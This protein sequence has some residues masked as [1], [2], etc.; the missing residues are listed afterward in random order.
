MCYRILNVFQMT[1]KRSNVPPKRGAR[2]N[3]RANLLRQDNSPS[4]AWPLLSNTIN[5]VLEVLGLILSQDHYR[6]LSH[7]KFNLFELLFSNF[8]FQNFILLG[9]KKVRAQPL[10]NNDIALSPAN[11]TAL[12]F[13]SFLYVFTETLDKFNSI[14]QIPQMGFLVSFLD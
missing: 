10:V 9:N 3:S 6:Q 12:G 13:T 5:F 11:D 4:W 1:K 7:C 2:K 8:H 14:L